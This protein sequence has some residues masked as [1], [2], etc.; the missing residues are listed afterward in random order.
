MLR[1]FVISLALLAPHVASAQSQ[2][3]TMKEL[4][5]AFVSNP[6]VAKRRFTDFLV[7][8][9]VTNISEGKTAGSAAVGFLALDKSQG[10]YQLI[11]SVTVN[12]TEEDVLTMS[13]GNAAT[14]RCRTSRVDGSGS[15][16]KL[17]LDGCRVAL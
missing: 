4:A 10:S 16:R 12:T 2:P 9:D 6:I 11:Y 7:T 14:F 13:V 1:S 8:G 15:R 5:D 3:V 17:A